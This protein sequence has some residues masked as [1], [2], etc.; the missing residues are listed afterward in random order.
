MVCLGACTG[1]LPTE[2]KI[3]HRAICRCRSTGQSESSDL[4]AVSCRTAVVTSPVLLPGESRHGQLDAVAEYLDVWIRERRNADTNTISL[5]SLGPAKRSDL[6]ADCVIVITRRLYHRLRRHRH[7]QPQ[8][9]AAISLPW[10]R[11]RVT[12]LPTVVKTT[13]ATRRSSARSVVT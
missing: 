6:S 13:A 1:P 3:A 7:Q 4:S 10:Q 5:G 11:R 8:R 2:T 12:S 9:R